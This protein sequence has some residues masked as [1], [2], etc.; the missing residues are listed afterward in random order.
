MGKAEI[1]LHPFQNTLSKGAYQ[2]LY[3]RPIN[4]LRA[5]VYN[6]G[7]FAELAQ[8]VAKITLGWLDSNGCKYFNLLAPSWVGDMVMAQSLFY[9]AKATLMKGYSSMFW[10]NGQSPILARC[11]NIRYMQSPYATGSWWMGSENFHIDGAVNFRPPRFVPEYYDHAI[12]MPP[13]GVECRH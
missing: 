1:E 8:G 6:M 10:P 3:R 5:L 12:I 7:I 9:Y 11:Q 4:K 13:L 2:E